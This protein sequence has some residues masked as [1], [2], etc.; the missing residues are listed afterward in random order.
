[1][2]D[3]RT[4][5]QA[6][7]ALSRAPP[8]GQLAILHSHPMAVTASAEVKRF[9]ETLKQDG[10]GGHKSDRGNRG[11]R[12]PV[13]GRPRRTSTRPQARAHTLTLR[14]PC[15]FRA[16]FP[17]LGRAYEASALSPSPPPRCL[18][19]APDLCRA[20][21]LP[22]SL[23]PPPGVFVRSFLLLRILCRFPL[24]TGLSDGGKRVCV[25][26]GAS[27][28]LPRCATVL[29]PQAGHDPLP[30]SSQSCALPFTLTAAS[31]LPLTHC[32][33]PT[34]SRCH[35]RVHSSTPVL[36]VRCVCV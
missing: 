1:M 8:L 18:A 6:Y 30:S 23:S 7:V 11:Y 12:H 21:A 20:C 15:V 14:I 26:A 16:S 22:P 13:P 24:Y 5:G 17:F 4:P 32:C 19:N 35:G 28:W 29:S 34:L 9:Y 3:M 25:C 27:Q 33:P 10:C 36:C 2:A 31:A